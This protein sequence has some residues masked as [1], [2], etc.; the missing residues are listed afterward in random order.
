MKS[1]LQHGLRTIFHSSVMKFVHLQFP[2]LGAFSLKRRLE[3]EGDFV[4]YQLTVSVAVCTGHH[5]GL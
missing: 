1:F 4:V 3:G 2:Q 5:F